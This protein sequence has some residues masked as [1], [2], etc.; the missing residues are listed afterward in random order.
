MTNRNQPVS[1]GVTELD[2]R[3]GGLFI[4]DNVIWYDEAG[5]LATPFTL[6]FIRASQDQERSL[7][8]VS[9]DR[10][11]RTV[12][13]ELGALAESQYL[14]ILDCFTYGKGD[15]SQ[16]FSKFYEKDG[17]QWPYQVVKVTEPDKPEKVMEAVYR[18]QQ[19]LKQDVRLVFESLTGMQDLWDGEEHILKFYSRAC[20]RLY[21]LETIAYWL[22]EKGAHSTRLKAHINQ[23]AQVV[24][25][26]TLKRGKATL[27]INKAQRRQPES[28]NQ[29]SVFWADGAKVHIED[30]PSTFGK[31]NI[32]LRLKGLRTRKGVSQ[33]Q[34]ARQVGVTP[35]TISQIEGNLI[36]PSLP[37]LVKMAQTL[38]VDISALFH[39]PVTPAKPSVFGAQDRSAAFFDLPKDA[40]SSQRLLPVEFDGRAEPYLI[41]IPAKKKIS[42]HFLA[43]K[44][45][46]MGYL[47]SGSLQVVI[48][49]TLHV[50]NRGDVVYLTAEIPSQWKNPGEDKAQLLWLKLK[51]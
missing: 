23:I 28:L 37:A 16:I 29:P 49:N 8:Y 31:L 48:N 26:L 20:P 18:V 19:S 10:S 6:S 44:G 7:I 4:G 2:Q 50:L 36:Y 9:F 38:A 42:G 14:I 25:D 41:E 33:K 11:P 13:E 51:P 46:E 39:E 32:G 21:E 12:V 45:E 3:L 43:H 27:T 30:D 47:L 40:L 1:T 24:V 15:G 22:I 34:L 5:S 35:S 17:A